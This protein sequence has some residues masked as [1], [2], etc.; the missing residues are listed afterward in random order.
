V[1]DQV[2]HLAG[3]PRPLLEPGL[4]IAEPDGLFQDRVA[5]VQRVHALAPLCA[6]RAERARHDH[7]EHDP[8]RDERGPRLPSRA[9]ASGNEPHSH[10]E[11][12]RQRENQSLAA[13]RPDAHAG[14]VGEYRH[15]DQQRRRRSRHAA[16]DQQRCRRPHVPRQDRTGDDGADGHVAHGH[17]RADRRE[18]SDHGKYSVPSDCCPAGRL[19][20]RAGALQL[21]AQ[22]I[23]DWRPGRGAPRS[24]RHGL[25]W[26]ETRS[27]R[28]VL[29]GHGGIIGEPHADHGRRAG[30]RTESAERLVCG[31]RCGQRGPCGR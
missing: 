1:A 23:R 11:H 3:D 14:A 18:E 20:P 28:I 22:A 13:A 5:L 6:D 27:D 25:P 9:L 15:G 26:R 17:V 4:D 8:D 31:H 24:R 10:R 2:M 7:Q 19:Q 12:R 30:G 16:C 21:G 29:P